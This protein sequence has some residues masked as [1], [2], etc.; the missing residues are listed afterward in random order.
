MGKRKEPVTGVEMTV[1]NLYKES[2]LYVIARGSRQ[3]FRGTGWGMETG[4]GVM[5]I[6]IR[7]LLFMVDGLVCALPSLSQAPPLCRYL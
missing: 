6:L 3:R 2:G 7:F 1:T 4:Q 5:N